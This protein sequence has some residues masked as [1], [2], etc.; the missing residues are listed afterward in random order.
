[1]PP[2]P[3]RRTRVIVTIIVF[4]ALAVGIFF[5]V[6]AAIDAV[7][8]RPPAASPSPTSTSAG[9]T[10]TSAEYGYS[11]EFPAEP[12]ETTKTVP[13]DDGEISVTSAVWENGIR[14][15]VATGATYP[16]GSRGDVNASLRS[17]LD[18]LVTNTPGAQVESSDAFTLAG[19]PA[20]KALIRTPGGDLRVVIAIEGDTQYQLVAYNLDETTAD[21]FFST[22]APA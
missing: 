13:S 11:I 21:G 20:V 22:F 1:M 17:A 14:S 6:R 2:E 3:S 12:A 19:I 18:S 10:Y 4:V 7:G 5:G 15:L 8:S 9:F 16:A